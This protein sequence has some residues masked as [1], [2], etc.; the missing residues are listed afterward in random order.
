MA[1]MA[2][3]YCAGLPHSGL[4]SRA[5]GPLAYRGSNPFPGANLLVNFLDRSIIIDRYA[6]IN[7][8]NSTEGHQDSDN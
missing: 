6:I 4:D 2:E 7:K 3:R 1:G 5:S 8:A